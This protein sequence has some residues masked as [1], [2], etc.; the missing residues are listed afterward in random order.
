MP[1]KLI[2]VMADAIAGTKVDPAKRAGEAEAVAA[3]QIVAARLRKRSE[4]F[5][6]AGLLVCAN[7]YEDVA[8]ELAAEIPLE[9][10]LRPRTAKEAGNGG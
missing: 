3:L 1:S 8:D 10:R 6:A 2:E 4:E 5:R 7:V 9:H